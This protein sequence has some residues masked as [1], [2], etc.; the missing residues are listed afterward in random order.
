MEVYFSHARTALKHGLQALGFRTGDEILV[1]AYICDVVIAPLNEL[2]VLPRYYSVS[3]DLQPIWD[4]LNDLV[5]RKTKGFLAAHYF[6]QPQDMVSYRS[7]SQKHGL[8]LIE[9]NAHGYGGKLDGKLLGTFGDIGISSPRKIMGW[10]NGGILHWNGEGRFPELPEQPG[11]WLWKI[12]SLA[13]KTL[14]GERLVCNTFRKMPDYHSQDIGREGPIPS[15]KMDEE[16]RNWLYTT[17]IA[18][19]VRLRQAVWHVWERWARQHGLK[20][21]YGQLSPDANPLAFVARTASVEESLKWFEWGWKR[22]LYVHSWPA[23]PRSVVAT[24]MATVRLWETLVCFSI[25]PGMKAERL[26]ET[27]GI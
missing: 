20:S 17:E 25:D 24:D 16:Y 14:C 12:K 22:R 10:R 5:G 13:K 8:L 21:I 4:C 7:F 23:L 1:P 2:G 19:T 3:A 27:L 11:K 6:G 15:W 18:Q 26:A 9:D